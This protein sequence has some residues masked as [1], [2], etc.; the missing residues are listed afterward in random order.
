VATNQNGV[1]YGD[2]TRINGFSESV[3]SYIAA[4]EKG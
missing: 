2:W 3:V 4:T 1:G